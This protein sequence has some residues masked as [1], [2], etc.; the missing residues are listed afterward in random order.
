VNGIHLALKAASTRYL[1]R[2]GFERHVESA[3]LMALRAMRMTLKI[4]KQR[5]GQ[6]VMK[7]TE[8]KRGAAAQGVLAACITARTQQRFETLLGE[9]RR[10]RQIGLNLS[11]AAF[12]SDHG[13]HRAAKWQSLSVPAVREELAKLHFAQTFART[14]CS[15][16]TLVPLSSSLPNLTLVA[17]VPALNDT[18]ASSTLER[19]KTAAGSCDAAK[20]ANSSIASTVQFAASK[21]ALELLLRSKGALRASGCFSGRFSKQARAA[22][23]RIALSNIGEDSGTQI[24]SAE[25][26]IID[27]DL[28]NKLK[29]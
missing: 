20:S 2:K 15:H 25:K 23:A 19:S 4:R 17:Q 13:E 7:A 5:C 21:A 16:G 18:L 9:Q 6:V 22:A 12:G 27:V 3:R 26:L 1:K 11:N 8:R 14:C 10:S 28:M 24:R 29:R